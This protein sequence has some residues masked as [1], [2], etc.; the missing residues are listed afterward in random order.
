MPQ[1]EARK[2]MK[3]FIALTLALLMLLSLLLSALADSPHTHNWKEVKRTDPTCTEK[4]QMSIM[5]RV[6]HLITIR[7]GINVFILLKIRCMK[8]MRS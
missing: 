2:I 5:S 8:L 3:R 6:F 4:G 1:K 7:A